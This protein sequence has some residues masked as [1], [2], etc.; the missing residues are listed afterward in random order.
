MKQGLAF[1]F[2]VMTFLPAFAFETFAAKIEKFDVLN[3]LL[4]I[5]FGAS[6]LS[7]FEALTVSRGSLSLPAF[8][9][10]LCHLKML[11]VASQRHIHPSHQPL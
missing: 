3:L 4:V 9:N 8:A 5:A 2:G 10:K 7:A 6:V 11:E 1:D